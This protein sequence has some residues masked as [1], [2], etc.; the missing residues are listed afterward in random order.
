MVI[1]EDSEMINYSFYI[2]TDFKKH[3]DVDI[4]LKEVQSVLKQLAVKLQT[5]LRINLDNFS[6]RFI[7]FQRF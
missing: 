3:Q 2:Q 6:K 5:Y 4:K 7:K 1:N